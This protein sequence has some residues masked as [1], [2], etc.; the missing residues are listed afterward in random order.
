MK[1]HLKQGLR[2]CTALAYTL[3]MMMSVMVVQADEISDVEAQTAKL[4]SQL[5]DINDELLQLS[6]EISST[7]MQIEITNS[8]ISRT[9]D[10]LAAAM[11]EEEEQF[12]KMG[13]RIK[14]I[15]EQ[16]SSSMLE[17]LFSAEDMTDFL[18]KAEF[19]QTVSEYDRIM[20]E[21]LKDTRVKIENQE[22]TL[23]N[24]KSSLNILQLDLIERQ[25]S[26][27]VLADETAVDLSTLQDYLKTLKAEEAA[28]K[29]EEARKAAEEA[30]KRQQAASRPSSSTPTSAT[31]NSGT[32]VTP[33]AGELDLLAA[34]IECE[35]IQDYDSLLAVATVIMNRV[36]SP[37]FPNTITEV[38]YA[39]GQFEPVW[40]GR[41]DSVLSTGATS[42]SYRVAQDAI[43][44]A[45][46]AAVA[47]C[48]YFLYA[49]ST[50][51]EGVNI[52]NNL[53]FQSW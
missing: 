13:E 52:G 39:P 15:Y 21:E 26:L 9:Q 44:G 45:R 22:K 10:S 41:L 32:V 33:A 51:R 5:A 16:G 37:S 1:M 48:Y 43:N 27:Q 50:D 35:A 25:N 40:T 34:L 8:E 47:D 4:S 53:F 17:L 12:D 42:L 19:I 6:E 3:S 2:A 14:F 18:N 11:A 29:A 7:E 36:E 30:A 24:Q 46:L 28:R 20:L 38:I 49:G 31:T 23:S